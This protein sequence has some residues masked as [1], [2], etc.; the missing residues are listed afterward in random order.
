MNRKPFWNLPGAMAGRV[1]IYLA[2]VSPSAGESWRNGDEMGR[3]WCLLR[4]HH[5]KSD[6]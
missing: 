6:P 3:S 1:L 2:S 5:K 4:A